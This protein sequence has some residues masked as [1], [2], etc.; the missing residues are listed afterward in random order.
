[1]RNGCSRFTRTSFAGGVGGVPD[2]SYAGHP[3]FYVQVED[4]SGTFDRI[5][6]RP[7]ELYVTVTLSLPWV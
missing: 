1:M 2:P 4:P 5:E 6:K 3:T 7:T